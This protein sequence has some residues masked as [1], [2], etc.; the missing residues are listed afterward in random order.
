MARALLYQVVVTAGDRETFSRSRV[1]TQWDDANDA[2]QA[3]LD[4]DGNVLD[5]KVVV[6]QHDPDYHE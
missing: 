1:Y 3:E 5:A 4:D 6:V 2:A